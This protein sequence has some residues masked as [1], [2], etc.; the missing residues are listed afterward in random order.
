MAIQASPPVVV[1]YSM[2]E[3]LEYR[4]ALKMMT[5]RIL[6]QVLQFV[7]MQHFVAKALEYR[8]ILAAV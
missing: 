3:A 6:F 4:A 1:Q 7:E 5:M 2:Q 8:A